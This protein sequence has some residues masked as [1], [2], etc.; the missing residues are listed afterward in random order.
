[1][2]MVTELRSRIAE[3]QDTVGRWLRLPG[4]HIAHDAVMKQLAED[5]SFSLRYGM[6]TALSS[7]I[8]ILGLLLS[9]PAVVIGAMLISP[10]MS[11]IILS[12][13]ALTTLDRGLAL[14][15]LLTLAAGAAM[16]VALAA[17]LVWLSPL[18]ELTP[19]IVARTRPNFFDLLVAVFAGIAGAYAVAQHKGEGLVGVAI[20]T[21]LMPPLAVVGFGVA[22]WNWAVFSGSAGLFMTNLLAIG[23]TASVVARVFGFGVHHPAGTTMWQT[24]SIVVVFGVLSIPLGFSLSRIAREAVETATVR[25][26]IENFYAGS[27]NQIYGVNVTFSETAPVHAEALVM[28]RKVDPG[29]ERRLQAALNARLAE[30]VRL[31]LSQVP[32]EA[33]RTVDAQAFDELTRRLTAVASARPPVKPDWARIAAL[34]FGL[35]LLDISVDETHR[36]VALHPG[37]LDDG[38]L[39]ALAKASKAFT[40]AHAGWSV[41]LRLDGQPLPAIPFASGS[42]TLDDPAKAMLADIAWALHAANVKAVAITGFSDSAVRNARA[43]RAAALK[44]AQGVAAVLTEAGIAATAEGVYPAP[45]QRQIE[46][47]LGREHF[48][49]AEIAPVSGPAPQ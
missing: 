4:R 49:R 12:G 28:V 45:D 7:A 15:G 47:D 14:R 3:A 41:S 18:K 19:E 38:K 21:A 10:L 26:T 32:I 46:R 20:A 40:A 13:Y 43:G 35:P 8:A 2:A 11:P 36:L 30:P 29:A 48:R 27:D 17:A 23:L 31:T 25:K 22:T 44:R 6:M 42:S 5:G 1:M 16:A 37:P 24:L 34:A 39:Q 33:K 9:S